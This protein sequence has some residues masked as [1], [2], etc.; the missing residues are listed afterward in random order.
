LKFNILLKKQKLFRR[1]SK[2]PCKGKLFLSDSQRD[3]PRKSSLH[4]LIL[5]R[6]SLPDLSLP[7]EVG[8]GLFFPGNGCRLIFVDGL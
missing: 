8:R 3:W 6:L 2:K 5:I 1:I 4:T 7:G